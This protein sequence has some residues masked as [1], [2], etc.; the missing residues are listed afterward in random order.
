VAIQYS[1]FGLLGIAI[2]FGLAKSRVS[3]FS[4]LFAMIA[5]FLAVGFGGVWLLGFQSGTDLFTR[6]FILIMFGTAPLI[7]VTLSRVTT[8]SIIRNFSRPN[9]GS[10]VAIALIAL[11]LM[12]SVFYSF[13]PYYYSTSIPLQSEDTRRY[14]PQWQ[15]MGDFVALYFDPTQHMWGPRLGASLVGLYANTTYYQFTVP[16]E[17]LI[18]VGA[19][20][21]PYLARLMP[22]EYVVISRTMSIAPDVQGYSPDIGTPLR[23]STRLYDNGQDVLLIAFA[24]ERLMPP[25]NSTN[26]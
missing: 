11:L 2:L 20:S 15:S 24:P 22:G 12:N 26:K 21:F 19:S 6:S 1:A 7:G 18:A 8:Y 4:K 5:L 17:G 23:I 16:T 14:L 25:S 3:F 9:L 10:L 13:P